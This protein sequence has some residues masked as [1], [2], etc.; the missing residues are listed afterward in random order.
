MVPA[1]GGGMLCFNMRPLIRITVATLLSLMFVTSSGA[2]SRFIFAGLQW[3]SSIEVVD[4]ALKAQ[5]FT[6]FN[7]VK[8]LAC[9]LQSVCY[10][11]FAGPTFKNG[12]ASFENGVLIEVTVFPSDIE[13]A[14][15]ALKKKYGS[16]AIIGYDSLNSSNRLLWGSRSGESLEVWGGGIIYR[17]KGQ[18]LQDTS[19]F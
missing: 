12:A 18:P 5:G 6:G 2:Q 4:A 17:S 3:G 15:T 11:E 16:P 7:K 14:L 19:K 10:L 8:K 1:L 13:A 9:V